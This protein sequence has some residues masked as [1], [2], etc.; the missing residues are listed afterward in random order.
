MP[1]TTF[2]QRVTQLTTKHRLLAE[3]VS[4]RIGPDG[5]ITAHPSRR[6][7]PRFPSR[8]LMLLL[9][10]AFAF[11]AALLVAS[12]DAAYTAR[13][14]E[15]AQGRGVEQAMAWVMQPDPVTQAI[16]SGIALMSQAAGA[17]LS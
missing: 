15:L 1:Q 16:V 9:A 5:L 12:G 7:L 3:G 2:D 4:Y 14:A 17:D 11:K 8:G 6:F 13:L 10:T